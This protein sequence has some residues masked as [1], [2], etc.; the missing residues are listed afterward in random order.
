MHCKHCGITID[1]DFN[2]TINISKRVRHG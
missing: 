2:T 1:R